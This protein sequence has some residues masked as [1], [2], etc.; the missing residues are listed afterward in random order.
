MPKQSNTVQKSAPLAKEIKNNPVKKPSELPKATITN[1]K[2]I[3]KQS[4]ETKQHELTDVTKRKIQLKELL[5]TR[6]ENIRTT[7]HDGSSR[8]LTRTEIGRDL[9]ANKTSKL[10]T[11]KVIPPAKASLTENFNRLKLGE[12]SARALNGLAILNKEPLPDK[13]P[14]KQLPNAYNKYEERRVKEL[15]PT[16]PLLK[17][18]K[19]KEQIFRDNLKIQVK[20]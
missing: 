6:S 3:Q 9:E 10:I 17:M 20:K 11:K 15:K 8:K 2:T 4:K 16:K 12:N 13:H 7:K 19:G 14:K 5:K 18:S 1:K